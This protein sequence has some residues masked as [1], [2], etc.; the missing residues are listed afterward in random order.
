MPRSRISR[1]RLLQSSG[2]SLVALGAVEANAQV[3]VIKPGTIKPVDQVQIDKTKIQVNPNIA[4]LLKKRPYSLIRADDMLVLELS[5]TNLS[6]T[7]SRRV[8]QLTNSAQAGF[9]AVHFPPQHVGEEAFPEP[10]G[11]VPAVA[12]ARLAG[13]SRL[14]FRVPAGHAPIPFTIES[15][16]EA[17]SKLELAVSDTARDAEYPLIGLLVDPKILFKSGKLLQGANGKLVVPSVLRS[18][19]LTKLSGIDL[20]KQIVKIPPILTIPIKRNAPYEPEADE[21]ALEIPYRL[22]LSPNR[23]AG[24]THALAPVTRGGRT[25]LWHTRMGVRRDADG[26]VVVDEDPP[27]P[28]QKTV[29]AI[30]SPDYKPQAPPTPGDYS[31]IRMS[32]NAR[33]RHELVALTSDFTKAGAGSRFVD[34]DRLM[35]T[36]LGGWL[37][38]LYGANPPAGFNLEAWRHRAAQGRDFYVRVVEKG[39]LLPFGHRVSLV[40][41][42]ERKFVAGVGGGIVAGLLQRQF[43]IVREPERNFRDRNSSVGR[44]FPFTRVRITTKETPPLDSVG[45]APLGTLGTQGFWPRVG[46]RDFLFHCVAE[47][48]NGETSEFA[49][50]MAFVYGTVTEADATR[51]QAIAGYA[52][53]GTRR[54]APL[55][56]QKVF[57]AE[58][59]NTDDTALQAVTLT[60]TVEPATSSPRFVPTLLSAQVNHPAVQELTGSVL[61]LSVTYDPVYA[62]SGFTTAAGSANVGEVF[63]KV[64]PA[65]LNYS[66]AVTGIVKPSLSVSGL[67]RRLGPVS[68]AKIQK[69]NFDPNEYFGAALNSKILG[70][71]KLKDI[72]G[73]TALQSAYAEVEEDGILTRRYLCAVDDAANRDIAIPRLLKKPDKDGVGSGM[74]IFD[75]ETT[76]LQN[77]GTFFTKRDG[78][79]LTLKAQMRLSSVAGT[80]AVAFKVT[81]KLVKFQLDFFSAIIIKIDKI[82]MAVDTEK[83]I[84]DFDFGLADGDD[85]IRFG[86]PLSFV[87]DLRNTLF[88][89]SSRPSGGSGGGGGGGGGGGA[90]SG[91][92]GMGDI[93]KPVIEPS[94]SPLGIKAGIKINIPE[95]TAGVFRISQLQIGAV[96]TIAFIEGPWR[97]RCNLSE[98]DK[99][100]LLAYLI[101]T[102]GIFFAITLAATWPESGPSLAVE[103]IEA[104]LEFGASYAINLGVASGGV[105][106]MV[107]IYF[108]W[109]GATQIATLTGYVR[110]G[111]SLKFL[112][113]VTISL[114]LYLALTY[115]SDG[116]CSGEATITVKIEILF[117]SISVSATARKEFSSAGTSGSALEDFDDDPMFSPRRRSLVCGP[118]PTKPP[119]IADHITQGDWGTYCDAFGGA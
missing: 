62:T 113:I 25:E 76:N 40:T 54:N 106:A 111:G 109:D 49:M 96:A 6:V 78:C 60:F 28:N 88:G 16:L 35:L 3:N 68:G 24:F 13:P 56:G 63:L 53:A 70:D 31:P 75:W 50:P 90:S 80:D 32:L 69:G 5:L 33:H 7:G 74:T 85:A 41:I 118:L 21:T 110:V 107:G 101:F 8:L 71:V 84:Q 119:K 2:S 37:D 46:G 18:R 23:N 66:G 91:G 61:P 55:G 29:R 12:Q 98:R 19:D 26:Q 43:L 17:I 117:F 30:W 67:S 99:P 27:S 105:Y 114:E 82:Q 14:V 103:K 36:A 87:N 9:L 39:F 4:E 83:G 104:A 112:G 102:G 44:R 58:S 94:F 65:D 59:V 1:R 86:G 42:T 72:L 100:C 34:V 79:K 51:N 116:T 38:S 57:F 10:P 48:V 108:E 15:V 47:D 20:Q 11:T 95:I 22:I 92:G 77:I 89:G 115:T 45:G 64:T 52:A 93:F 81:S 97:L 73:P